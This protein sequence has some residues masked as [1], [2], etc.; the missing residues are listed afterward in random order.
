M[1]EKSEKLP[2]RPECEKILELVSGAFAAG[3]GKYHRLYLFDNL[4]RGGK[5]WHFLIVTS[6]AY[7][8]GLELAA[9][10]FEVCGDGSRTVREKLESRRARL[11]VER[12]PE[13]IDS[14]IIRF[15]EADCDYREYDLSGFRDRRAQ[16]DYLRQALGGGADDTEA[17]EEDE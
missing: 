10:S 17:G 11:P 9:F 15:D 1:E 8:G 6:E 5:V 14:L 3:S 16:L 4:T 2:C 12:L 7:E 13:V